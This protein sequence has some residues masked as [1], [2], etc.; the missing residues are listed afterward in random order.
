MPSKTKFCD[1]LAVINIIMVKGLMNGARK[2]DDYTDSFVMTDEIL[3]GKTNFLN[4]SL[5]Y[6]SLINR[7]VQ[8][9]CIDQIEVLAFLKLIFNTFLHILEFQSLV[10]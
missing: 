7:H 8:A 5:I 2:E 6:H 1:I 4:H 3:Q 10:K 9:I